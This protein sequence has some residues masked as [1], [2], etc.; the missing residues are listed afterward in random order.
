M[1]NRILLFLI[2]FIFLVTFVTFTDKILA[3]FSMK[4][5]DLPEN[6]IT[7]NEEEIAVSA[8]ITDLPSASYFRIAW[9]K[10]SGKQYF[11]Y[12]KGSSGDWIKITAGEDCKNYF[13]V[14][15]S[16]TS[17]ITLVTKIGDD[18]IID[19][20]SYTLKLRRYTASCSSYSDS[21]PIAVT[22]NLPTP[23]PTPTF[24]PTSNPTPT[25]V[26][27]PLKTLTPTP[28]VTSTPA[29]SISAEPLAEPSASSG[30]SQVLSAADSIQTAFPN[31]SDMSEPGKN[32]LPIF[33]L[34][35]VASGSLFIG[36]A[37]YL[38]IKKGRQDAI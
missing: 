18:N 29:P 22:V 30:E 6:N 23:T 24:V 31:T 27:T 10:E 38:A 11:G 33:A 13:S 7:S 36:G 35:L 34:S 25:L 32:S 8:E 2:F 9:Q 19:N 3:A 20:S 12:M 16:S 15:D 5:L 28:R 26:P 4:L 1:T 21:N 37:I 14:S 17:A